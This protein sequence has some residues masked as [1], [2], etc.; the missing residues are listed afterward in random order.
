L[1]TPA[2]YK[3]LRREAASIIA[4]FATPKNGL[5]AE[6]ELKELAAEGLTDP[7]RRLS[8]WRARHGLA[9]VRGETGAGTRG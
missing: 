1:A 6:N 5:V 4:T 8:N 7:P 3:A 2:S 9:S